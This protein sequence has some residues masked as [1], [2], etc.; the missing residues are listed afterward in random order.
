MRTLAPISTAID[1]HWVRTAQ[2]IIP[3]RLPARRKILRSKTS[4]RRPRTGDRT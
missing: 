2:P 3:K 4:L 1:L